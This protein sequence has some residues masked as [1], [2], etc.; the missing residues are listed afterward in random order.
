M[1]KIICRK[2]HIKKY[3]S[4][5]SILQQCYKT[6]QLYVFIHTII[7]YY[8]IGNRVDLVIHYHNYISKCKELI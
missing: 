5:F 3:H 6:Y 2:M 4:E 7:N 1:K 8:Y